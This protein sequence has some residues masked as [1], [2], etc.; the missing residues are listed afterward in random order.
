VDLAFSVGIDASGNVYVA[1]HTD[2]ALPGQTSAGGI[3]AFVRAYDSAGTERCTRQFG[4]SG[5][6]S[7]ESVGVDASGNVY[8]AGWTEGA[9]PNQTSAGFRDA[10]VRAYDGAG[11]ER[12]ILHNRWAS[13]CAE[14]STSQGTPTVLYPARQAR[15]A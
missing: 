3:D 12:W 9:L 15:E 13:T 1:G 10:F 2:G 8:A 11:T 7:V 4:S 14:R 5:H 6:D